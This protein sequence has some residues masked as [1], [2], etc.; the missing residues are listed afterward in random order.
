MKAIYLSVIVGI[1]MMMS[2]TVAGQCPRAS[3]VQAVE[4]AVDHLD[5]FLDEL[6]T[7]QPKVRW[8]NFIAL[9]GSRN[10]NVNPFTAFEAD[11]AL[12]RKRFIE[13]ADVVVEKQKAWLQ[14]GMSSNTDLQIFMRNDIACYYAD[15]NLHTIQ[16]M[17]ARA[18]IDVQ[19]KSG[20][21]E[22][23]MRL[24]VVANDA[25][26]LQNITSCIGIGTG[27]GAVLTQV[28]KKALG[29]WL[30]LGA[31]LACYLSANNTHFNGFILCAENYAACL[32]L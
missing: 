10:D 4:S 19:G 1:F 18:G 5:R 20:G 29:G 7:S 2:E 14:A 26:Y 11:S 6:K 31:G 15:S 21:C 25:S 13:L 23:D 8:R 9:T 12:I 24:C 28:L 3:F 27:A 22:R 30:A 17:A 16:R 32:G